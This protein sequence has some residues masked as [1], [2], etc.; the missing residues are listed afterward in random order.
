M[1]SVCE[2][3]KKI[4]LRFFEHLTAGRMAEVVALFTEDGQFWGLPGTD[5]Y[6]DARVSKDPRV[7]HEQIGRQH[8]DEAWTS[9]RRG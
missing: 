7:G 3:N 1:V 6:V 4:A 9:Y 2:E 8:R 5:I